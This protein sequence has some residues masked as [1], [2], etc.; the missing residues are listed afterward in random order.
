MRKLL[1]KKVVQALKT[2]L[3]ES[4]ERLE[5]TQKQVAAIFGIHESTVSGWETGK[6]LIPLRKLIKY[7]DLFHYS[8]DYI[9]KLSDE[10]NWSCPIDTINSK[11]IGENLKQIRRKN[12]HSQEDVANF[13]KISQSCYSNYEQGRELINTLSLY[14]IAKTY[15]ISI[16]ELLGRKNKIGAMQ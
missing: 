9:L 1:Y 5:M 16:D 15:H 3:K 14:T 4:R 11:I 2:R 10:N 13:M 8:L 6:D 7:C 12:G